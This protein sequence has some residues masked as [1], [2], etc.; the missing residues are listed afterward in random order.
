MSEAAALTLSHAIDYTYSIP[1]RTREDYED[2]SIA[3]CL[4]KLL[5]DDWASGPYIFDLACGMAVGLCH[6]RFLYKRAERAAFERRDFL[7][8][9]PDYDYS[10]EI[11][12]DRDPADGRR[13]Y[14]NKY[15]IRTNRLRNLHPA[16]G[17]GD[18]S[19]ST[20]LPHADYETASFGPGNLANSDD[21]D[22]AP[23]ITRITGRA[24]LSFAPRRRTPKRLSSPAQARL[25]ELRKTQY[26]GA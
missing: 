24:V 6:V 11:M 7:R 23:P 2:R 10:T 14:E 19:I 17:S 26:F 9:L 21:Q 1:A 13:H 5:R 12:L 20:Y 15:G 22:A 3:L 25:I 8:A 4:L 16:A 18:D